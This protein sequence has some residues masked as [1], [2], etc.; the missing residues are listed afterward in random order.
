MAQNTS[1]LCQDSEYCICDVMLCDWV[2]AQYNGCSLDDCHWQLAHAE[3][4]FKEDLDSYRGFAKCATYDCRTTVKASISNCMQHNCSCLRASSLPELCM[5]FCQ[6]FPN[7]W[8]M[9]FLYTKLIRWTKNDCFFKFV[10]NL[11]TL[12]HLWYQRI[13]CLKDIFS[14]LGDNVSQLV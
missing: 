14:I 10:S 9:L 1:T 4:V 2:R 11:D 5:V 13:A 3:P 6:L 7:W 8:F 12:W